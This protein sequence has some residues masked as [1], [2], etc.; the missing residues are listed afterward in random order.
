M[1]KKAMESHVFTSLITVIVIAIILI[2]GFAL[3]KKTTSSVEEIKL[4][5]FSNSLRNDIEQTSALKAVRYFKY[6]LPAIANKV[7]I[8]DLGNTG[9]LL[10]NDYV[11]THPIIADAIEGKTGENLFIVDKVDNLVNSFKIGDVSLGQFGDEKCSGIA[12]IPVVLSQIE[13]KVSKKGNGMMFLGEECEGLKYSVFRGPFSDNIYP[14]ANYIGRIERDINNQRISLRRNLDGT[15]M[16]NGTGIARDFDINGE[17]DRLFFDGFEPDGTDILLQIDFG[18]GTYIGPDMTNET[19][20]SYS[21]QYITKPDV[22]TKV[23][24]MFIL[25]TDDTKSKS[26]LL[27]MIR[28]SYYE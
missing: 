14:D 16:S 25:F 1:N 11:K 28:L 17:L 8:V 19:Y 4:A 7:I 9:A 26:P 13:L 10:E 12:I 5:G 2:F 20:Y 22:I 15:Y 18:N 21:G 23:N 6:D 3:V 24:V 27:D